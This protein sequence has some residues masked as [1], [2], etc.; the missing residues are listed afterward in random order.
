MAIEGSSIFRIECND[1]KN[2]HEYN[3]EFWEN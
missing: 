2:P 1:A 3:C